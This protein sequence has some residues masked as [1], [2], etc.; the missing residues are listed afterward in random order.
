MKQSGPIPVL[1]LVN[2]N[3]Q[4]VEI[5]KN[6]SGIPTVEDL[7]KIEELEQQFSSLG[8]DEVSD[9]YK[10]KVQLYTDKYPFA[11]KQTANEYRT[12]DFICFRKGL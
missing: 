1:Q 11:T 2:M 9:I 5:V 10:K 12:P 7:L 8:V 6:I 4:F 3:P